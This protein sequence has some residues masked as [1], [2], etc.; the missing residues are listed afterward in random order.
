VLLHNV[1]NNESVGFFLQG[2]FRY[3]QL[4][5]DI[6]ENSNPN[7]LALGETLVVW[8]VTNRRIFYLS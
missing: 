2:R 4:F 1:A 5:F 8:I 3:Q 6:Q 7:Q